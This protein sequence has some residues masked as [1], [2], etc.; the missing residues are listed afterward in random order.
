[1]SDRA[2]RWWLRAAVAAP[3]LVAALVL[4][5]RPWSPV[6]DRAMTE[7]RVRDV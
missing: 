3:L 6:R 5:R 4:L 2:L 1:M 7:V